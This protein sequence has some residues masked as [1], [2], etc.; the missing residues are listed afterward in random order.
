LKNCFI[1][2]VLRFDFVS[3]V[4]I[5]WQPL[6]QIVKEKSLQYKWVV[7]AVFGVI[8]IAALETRQIAHRVKWR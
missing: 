6:Y 7:A 2:V 1:L 5:G 8:S 3:H 4:K